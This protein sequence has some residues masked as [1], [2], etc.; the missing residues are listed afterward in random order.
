MLPCEYNIVAKEQSGHSYV[1]WSMPIIKFS[2]VANFGDHPLHMYLIQFSFL[3]VSAKS[4]WRHNPTPGP[5]LL[6]TLLIQNKYLWFDL[7]N[8]KPL[9]PLTWS[10]PFYK[11]L[12]SNMIW[13]PKLMGKGER[14]AWYLEL[15]C[16]SGGWITLGLLQVY[17]GRLGLVINL[18][19][20]A[21]FENFSL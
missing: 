20:F 17:S 16:S 19:Y 21:L 14:I 4:G 6:V 1:F 18:C 7:N 2:P 11:N 13:L 12:G 5:P 9:E 10:R 3:H 15:V 8:L